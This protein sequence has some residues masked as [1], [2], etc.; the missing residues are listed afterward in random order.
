[1][2]T[3]VAMGPTLLLTGQIYQEV[4]ANVAEA[5]RLPLAALHF[6]PVRANGGRRLFRA[7]AGAAG[8]LHHHGHR[9]AVLAHKRR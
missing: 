4:V 8:P 7:A 2:L 6:Y 5:P 1:M 3:P 9:L